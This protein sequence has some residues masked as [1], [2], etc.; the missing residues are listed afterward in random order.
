[1]SQ[2]LQKQ[3]C[4][5][6]PHHGARIIHFANGL[7]V[8][9]ITGI[10]LLLLLAWMQ[11]AGAGPFDRSDL[12]HDNSVDSLD[13]EI[14]SYQY[15]DQD[16]ETVNWCQFYRSSIQN[17]KNFRRLTSDRIERYLELL[18][19]I[20]LSYNCQTADLQSLSTES[21]LQSA[22]KSD[23]S[24]DQVVDLADLVIF[25]TNY[26]ETYWEAVDWCLFY[27]NTLAGLDYEGQRTR[28]FLKHFGQ[29][30]SFINEYFYCGGEEPPPT[31]LLLENTPKFLA[32]IADAPYFTGDY[33]ITD[34]KIGSLFIYDASLV[35]KAEIKGL[36][37]PLGV[38]VDSR[39]YIL[40]GNNGRD[41]IE[42]YDPANGD[43][44]TVFAEGLVK[45]PTAITLDSL[46]NIYVTDS[47]SNSVQVFDSAYNQLR[48]I[49]KSSARGALHFP[50]DTEIVANME[51]FVADQVNNRIQVYDL[52]G[53]WLRSITFDGTP[54]ENC[55]WMTGVCEIPGAPPFTR[56]QALETDSFGRLHVLDNFGAKVLIF[57]PA[58]GSFLGSY[59]E[60][61][62]EAGF[63]RVPMDVL[64]SDSGTAIVT[65]GDGDRIE[66]YAVP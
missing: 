48:V 52:D 7:V 22:D 16:W 63:L 30:L 53:K 26:L 20:A 9:A 15:L 29:L 1:M 6:G 45:M 32:R 54:G 36:N 65:S 21:I 28:Y 31:A 5:T 25:S 55:S 12:N 41:N 8:Q 50:T 61:G 64:V 58:D 43:L 18:N 3:G 2:H 49:G 38:A 59:G 13:L 39:G 40:V 24:N 46:G 66:V 37:K 51:V 33:Y 11:L 17:E 10:F 47:L 44:V 57:N 34:P 62:L 60:Y 19:Y 42:V 35:L 4:N 23:L 56:L 27:E 14:F